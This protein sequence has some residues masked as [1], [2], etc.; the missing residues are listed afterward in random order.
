M[1]CAS[2]L[3][4]NQNVGHTKIIK[5]KCK[6]WDPQETEDSFNKML[7]SFIIKRKVSQWP[8]RYDESWLANIKTINI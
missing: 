6:P 2:H 8:C 5:D 1:K 3:K 7:C 4:I